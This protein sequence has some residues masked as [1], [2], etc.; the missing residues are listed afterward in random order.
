MLNNFFIIISLLILY[1][2]LLSFLNK[3]NKNFLINICICFFFF[4][5]LVI[6][7]D[8]ITEYNFIGSLRGSI[9]TYMH[10]IL[11]KYTIHLHPIQ[12]NKILIS[13]HA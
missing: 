4:S 1:L 9:E 8:I 5:Y 10:A 3:F 2:F 7:L 12:V 6:S 13:N 11:K